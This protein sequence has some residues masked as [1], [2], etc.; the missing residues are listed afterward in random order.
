LAAT[1]ADHAEVGAAACAGGECRETPPLI[2]TIEDE[3]R[4][5]DQGVPLKRGAYFGEV[6]SYFLA[7]QRSFHRQARVPHATPILAGL[8]TMI[9]PGG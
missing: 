3:R 5:V 9:S 4:L 8:T 6:Y 2:V 7:W 1:S